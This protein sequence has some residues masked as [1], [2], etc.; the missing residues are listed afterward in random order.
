M[1]GDDGGEDDPARGGR[2]TLDL[3]RPSRR[4]LRPLSP[5]MFRLRTGKDGGGESKQMR[6]N[7]RLGRLPAAPP[8]AHHQ[9]SRD[10]PEGTGRL[11]AVGQ[12]DSKTPF[13]VLE[14]RGDRMLVSFG[15]GP[16]G[17]IETE[18]A[19]IQFSQPFGRARGFPPRK[20]A[21]APA[22]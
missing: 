2:Y 11:G 10:I 20:P 22:G 9:E 18:N 6:S 8:W 12:L 4:A 5:S 1:A 19:Q 16:V 17:W 3:K 21:A 7:L 14:V 15:R 13:P